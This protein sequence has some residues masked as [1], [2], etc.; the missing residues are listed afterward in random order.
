MSASW[1]QGQQQQQPVGQGWGEPA[2]QGWGE[3]AGQQQRP[4]T[5]GGGGRGSGKLLIGVALGVAVTLVV[6]AVLLLTKAMSFGSTPDAATV[7]SS[8]ISLPATLGTMK[9]RDDVADAKAKGTDAAK[10]SASR[11]AAVLSGPP[12]LV[13]AIT[14]MPGGVAQGCRL[15]WWRLPG[16]S[17]VGAPAGSI[18]QPD[19]RRQVVP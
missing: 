8:P 17:R 18:P 9:D 10:N 12:P 19:G 4:P 1:D 13:A 16:W 7:D 5:T 14:R 2:G 6:A 15:T 11:R 3:P